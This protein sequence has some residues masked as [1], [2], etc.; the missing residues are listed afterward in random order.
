MP[1][2]SIVF[3]AIH[4][5]DTVTLRDVMTCPICPSWLVRLEA[6]DIGLQDWGGSDEDLDTERRQVMTGTAEADG[7]KA[8]MVELRAVPSFPPYQRRGSWRDLDPTLS[9]MRVGCLQWQDC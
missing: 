3:D 9:P 1:T 8:K 4:H 5:L 2:L 7:S 6:D